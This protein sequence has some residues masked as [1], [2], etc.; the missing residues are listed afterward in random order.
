MAHCVRVLRG[1]SRGLPQRAGEMIFEILVQ[2]I[3]VFAMLRRPKR[4]ICNGFRAFEY[5]KI[6]LKAEKVERAPKKLI[7]IRLT[8]LDAIV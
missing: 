8:Q 5:I 1:S 4:L 3:T 6:T 7:V 2:F